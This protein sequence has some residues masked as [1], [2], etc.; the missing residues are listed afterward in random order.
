MLGAKRNWAFWIVLGAAVSKII[1]TVPEYQDRISV[2]TLNTIIILLFIPRVI[3]I[4]ALL[5][6][7]AMQGFEDA[8]LLLAPVYLSKA[9]TLI[10]LTYWIAFTAN[11]NLGSDAWINHTFSW[12]FDVSLDNIGDGLFLLGMLAILIWRFTRTQRREETYD[13]WS[14]SPL[15]QCSSC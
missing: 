9:S 8:R 2:P 15:A 6:R 10:S 13:S 14:A 5:L 1:L 12:P 3:W 4:L 11:W 7:R